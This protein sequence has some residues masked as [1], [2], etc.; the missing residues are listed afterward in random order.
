M[1]RKA[2]ALL[3]INEPDLSRFTS[4]KLF[5][6]VASRTPVLVHGDG[7]KAA[8][9]LREL[10]TGFVVQTDDVAGPAQALIALS[11][12]SVGSHPVLI[13]HWPARCSRCPCTPPRPS[14]RPARRFARPTPKRL[15]NTHL[16]AG[17]TCGDSARESAAGLSASGRASGSRSRSP[18]GAS[19]RSSSAGAGRHGGCWPRAGCWRVGG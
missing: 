15:A 1:M 19:A 3:I 4:G 14:T 8:R 11:Q 12:S 10:G 5:D 17:T 16:G 7:G 2:R 18:R 13:T 6:Y 9:N